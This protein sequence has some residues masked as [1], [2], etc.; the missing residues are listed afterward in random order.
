LLEKAM[1]LVCT[2][3]PVLVS[4]LGLSPA[5]DP[6]KERPQGEPLVTAPLSI[7]DDIPWLRVRVNGSAPLWFILDSGAGGCVLSYP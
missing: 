7:H 3:A 6:P 4:V 5:A 1:R 2:L